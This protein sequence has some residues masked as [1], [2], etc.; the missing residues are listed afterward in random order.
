MSL[1][2]VTQLKPPWTHVLTATPSDACD[3][4]WGLEAAATNRMVVRMVRGRK[5]TTR[6]AFFDESAAA[7]QFPYYFGENWDAYFDCIRDLS[8]LRAD[9]LVVCISDANRLLEAAP[10]DQLE[11]FVAVM[12]DTAT[13]WN[14]PEKGHPAKPFHLVLQ[15]A[16]GEEAALTERVQAA[17]MKPGR[18]N[19]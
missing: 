2:P 10:S 18:L 6:E 12:N 7:L 11:R 16:P 4:L 5:S 9:A 15:V 8:W 14:K 1:Q 3:A 19:V 17:G 13:S